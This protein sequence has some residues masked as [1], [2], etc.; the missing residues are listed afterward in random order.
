VLKLEDLAFRR[1]CPTTR[2]PGDN[3]ALQLVSGSVQR[4]SVIY[5]RRHLL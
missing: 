2:C 5:D 4:T 3:I 1:R